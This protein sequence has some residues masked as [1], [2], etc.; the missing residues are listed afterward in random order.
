MGTVPRQEFP[1]LLTTAPCTISNFS[2]GTVDLRNLPAH[3]LIL[4]IMQR[5]LACIF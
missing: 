3:A 1:Y 5:P 2:N 4:K